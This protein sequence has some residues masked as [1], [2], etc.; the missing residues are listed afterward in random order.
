MKWVHN[1]LAARSQYT[2]VINKTSSVI[3]NNCGVLQGAAL[4]PFFF[5]LHTSDLYSESLAS[6]LKYADDVVSGHP[7]KDSQG[8]VTIYNALKYVSDW[9]GYNGFNLNPSKCVQCM[10]N[11]KGNAVTDLDFKA[12]INGKALFEVES[13]T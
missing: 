6:F 8:I 10:F 2:R 11:L 9:P 1:Y 3:P 13:A 4:S 7:C 12:N 5:T